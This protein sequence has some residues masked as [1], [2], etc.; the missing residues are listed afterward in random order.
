MFNSINFKEMLLLFYLLKFA[1]LFLD[2][3][4]YIKWIHTEVFFYKKS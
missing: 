4:P 2:G 3:G 1:L